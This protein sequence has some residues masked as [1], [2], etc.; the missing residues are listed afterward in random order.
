M[1][2]S[3]SILVFLFIVWIA[4]AILLLKTYDDI[5]GYADFLIEFLAIVSSIMTV[6]QFIEYLKRQKS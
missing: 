6:Y 1:I 2:N 3:K 4:L 5:K